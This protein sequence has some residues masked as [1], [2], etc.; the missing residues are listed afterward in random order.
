MFHSLLGQRTAT[1]EE[2]N[3]VAG[4]IQEYLKVSGV[5]DGYSHLLDFDNLF[6]TNMFQINPTVKCPVTMTHIQV[7]TI[8]F[9]KKTK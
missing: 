4:S 6:A 3:K 2:L 5:K 8:L 9:Y 7:N 1:I